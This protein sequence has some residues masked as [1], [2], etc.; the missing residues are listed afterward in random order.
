MLEPFLSPV[1]ALM[2]QPTFADNIPRILSHLS[3]L[4][5]VTP[6]FAGTEGR[7]NAGD[8]HIDPGDA[9]HPAPAY[10]E[11]TGDSPG[12]AIPIPDQRCP[13]EFEG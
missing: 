6:T 4:Q 12:C 7:C 3:R 9:A 11:G 5:G 13:G 10:H 1:P 2:L 8:S